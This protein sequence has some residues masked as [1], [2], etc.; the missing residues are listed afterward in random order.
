M[1][2][3]LQ[4]IVVVIAISIV[5]ASSW[6]GNNSPASTMLPA[7]DYTGEL[8]DLYRMD[9]LFHKIDSLV[10]RE[11]F[12]KALLLV[13]PLRVGEKIKLNFREY[14]LEQVVREQ[15]SDLLGVKVERDND[16][17][18]E[19]N[20]KWVFTKVKDTTCNSIELLL[21][22]ISRGSIVDLKYGCD[23]TIFS[24][25]SHGTRVAGVAR[26]KRR[27]ELGDTE[28]RGLEKKLIKRAFEDI[29][30][31]KRSR[32]IMTRAQRVFAVYKR[33]YQ[34]FPKMKVRLFRGYNT[35]DR[36]GSDREVSL[37]STLGDTLRDID[38]D[39]WRGIQ[40]GS[41]KL[42]CLRYARLTTVDPACTFLRAELRPP[43]VNLYLVDA[44]NTEDAGDTGV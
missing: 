16:S 33:D 36:I 23:S 25:T 22:D 37:L 14:A 5:P 12:A 21:N 27:N 34:R 8:E 3:L 19:D 4:L 9:G 24:T 26:V 29:E 7:G 18:E 2:S 11:K 17:D 38:E 35:R 10:Q 40:E 28:E 39:V 41:L 32:S 44:S 13:C 43:G 6:R 42:C 30:L 20:N 31:G 15:L 1:L